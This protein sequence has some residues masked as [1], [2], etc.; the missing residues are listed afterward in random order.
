M[1]QLSVLRQESNLRY[2]DADAALLSRN[3]RGSWQDQA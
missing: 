1:S 3:Y 2:C